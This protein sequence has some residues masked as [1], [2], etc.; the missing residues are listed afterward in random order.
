MLVEFPAS[1]C[2]AGQLE[3]VDLSNN[4][5]SAVTPDVRHL[6]QLKLLDLSNNQF[7]EFPLAVRIA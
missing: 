6:G 2:D 1:I 7:S 4:S 3:E 5:I